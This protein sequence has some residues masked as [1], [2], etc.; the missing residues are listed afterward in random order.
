MDENDEVFVHHPKAREARRVIVHAIASAPP[1]TTAIL[2][3]GGLDTSIIAEAVG[4]RQFVDAITVSC[5][6]DVGNPKHD[7]SYAQHIARRA[8]LNHHVVSIPDTLSIMDP[9]PSGALYLAVQTLQTFDPMELRGGVAVARALLHA[10]SLGITSIVT[11]DGADE[12][13]AGYSFVTTLA[14]DKLN[15]WRER[16]A[17]HMQFCAT[18]LG[19]ALGI[20]VYQ[21]FVQPDV[22][23]FALSCTKA[24][25]VAAHDGAI[26][27]KFVLRA[28]F[29]EAFS[30]WRDKVPLETGAGT[31]PL[32]TLFDHHTPTDEFDQERQDILAQDG[33]AVRSAE[34]LHYYRVFRTIFHR[35]NGA[36]W[37]TRVRRHDSDPC[38][39]CGFQLERPDQ[40]F[41]KTCGA[42]PARTSLPPTS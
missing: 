38:V 26:H 25:L 39:Q 32:G 2:L 8:K 36:D 7:L 35:P 19:Q 34:H 1:G 14:E 3:S 31:T 21:P 40:Y 30:R 22:V 11:G 20:S 33:I 6:D 18:K 10:Q 4:G 5:G 23:A 17:K 42:W 29:P 28:A 16:A 37:T 41:C 24:D 12:M 9:S 13:F 27:G 15:A